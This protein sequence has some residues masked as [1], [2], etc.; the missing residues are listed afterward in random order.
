VEPSRDE[1]IAEFRR[2]SPMTDARAVDL[3][4]LHGLVEMGWN[5][6][7]DAVEND[8]AV[9]RERERADLAWWQARAEEALGRLDL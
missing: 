4:L 3:G 6:A 1:L 8:D 7:L 5:K 2:L 9:V